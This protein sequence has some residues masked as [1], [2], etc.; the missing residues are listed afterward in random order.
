M[1]MMIR[2]ALT[3]SMGEE[4]LAEKV[5]PTFGGKYGFNVSCLAAP[6]TIKEIV[7]RDEVLKMNGVLDAVIAHYP[8]ETIT[9]NMRGLLAQ[10]VI[11]ILG[12]VDR[13]DD[14]YG[15]M[16]KIEDGIRI[17]ST[18]GKDLKL[19]GIEPKDVEGFVL[20]KE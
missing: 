4:R 11:R 6:G 13:L 20:V 7:G 10:I 3:G 18:E 17:I 14:L 19:D 12:T 1:E 15:T 8:G 5:D 16:K 9:E 2:F